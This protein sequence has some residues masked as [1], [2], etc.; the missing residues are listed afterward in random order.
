MVVPDDDIRVLPDF[1]RSDAVVQTQPA[2]ASAKATAD[3]LR[4]PD[5]VLPLVARWTRGLEYSE[6]RCGRLTLTIRNRYK[7]LLVKIILFQKERSFRCVRLL[8]D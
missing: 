2:S 5:R 3:A 4:A 6:N 1:E 8:P 7:R